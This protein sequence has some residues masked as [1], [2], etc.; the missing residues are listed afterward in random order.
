MS[1]P[2]IARAGRGRR[3]NTDS[4]VPSSVRQRLGLSSP[5]LLSRWKPQFLRQGGVAAESLEARVRQLEAEP[6]RVERKDE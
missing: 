2:V 6:K 1:R 3:P 4:K 5:T